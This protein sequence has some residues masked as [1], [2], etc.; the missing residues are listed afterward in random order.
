MIDLNQYL[1]KRCGYNMYKNGYQC[2]DWN[3][4]AFVFVLSILLITSPI[5]IEALIKL[6]DAIQNKRI[7]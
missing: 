4:V 2:P 5:W 6:K 7:I 3:G 1:P